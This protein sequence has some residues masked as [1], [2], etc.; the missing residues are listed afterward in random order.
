[1]NTGRIVRVRNRVAPKDLPKD[2]VLRV[3]HWYNSFVEIWNSAETTFQQKPYKKVP[4]PTEIYDISLFVTSLSSAPKRVYIRRRD[5]GD[6][7]EINPGRGWMYYSDNKSLAVHRSLLDSE[8]VVWVR[9]VTPESEDSSF[10]SEF[11]PI[12]HNNS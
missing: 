10:K 2:Q 12:D 6:C 7:Y 3:I 9:R 8:K 1:M 11:S 5:T 4:S